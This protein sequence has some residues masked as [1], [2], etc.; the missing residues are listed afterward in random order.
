MLT[1][2]Q[3]YQL[4]HSGAFDDPGLEAWSRALEADS[5]E[6][7]RL[8]LTVWDLHRTEGWAPPPLAAPDGTWFSSDQLIASVSR[9]LLQT[10]AESDFSHTHPKNHAQLEEQS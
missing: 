4:V 9:R 10:K 2:A 7:R 8:W 5:S 1:V 3:S 6:E